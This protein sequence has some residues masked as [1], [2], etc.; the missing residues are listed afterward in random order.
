MLGMEIVTTSC[1][2]R[3]SG[4]RAVHEGQYHEVHGPLR[5]RARK[6]ARCMFG[7][8]NRRPMPDP[9]QEKGDSRNVP[10]RRLPRLGV[11][12]RVRTRAGRGAGGA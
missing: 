3:P 8:E 7:V 6:S 1:I 9:G 4:E 12:A 2:H 10:V 11:A 5:R